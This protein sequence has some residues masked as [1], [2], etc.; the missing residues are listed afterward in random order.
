MTKDGDNISREEHLMWCG[1]KEGDTGAKAVEREKR[2]ED[3]RAAQRGLF[4]GR[5]RLC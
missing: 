2:G 4:K 3:E 5:E 1:E